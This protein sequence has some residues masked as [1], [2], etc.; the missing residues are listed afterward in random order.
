MEE[1]DGC[2]SASN[3]SVYFQNPPGHFVQVIDG[4]VRPILLIAGPRAPGSNLGL[5][6]N[7]R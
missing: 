6:I 7:L 1:Y 4:N 3:H 5:I 2:N